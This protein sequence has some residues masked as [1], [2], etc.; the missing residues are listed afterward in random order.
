LML[1]LSMRDWRLLRCFRLFM[2]GRWVV[3]YNRHVWTDII[4]LGT[5]VRAAYRSNLN[6]T[7][8]VWLLQSLSISDI[9]HG[10]LARRHS[11]NRLNCHSDGLGRWIIDNNCL[12][13][14]VLIG[15]YLNH[16]RWFNF[17]K[18]RTNF[19]WVFVCLFAFR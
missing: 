2:A 13:A 17:V 3:L 12:N 10:A 6:K 9:M 15:K 5:D 16:L 11:L 14:L 1:W 19:L 4:K 8:L 7:A 18:F